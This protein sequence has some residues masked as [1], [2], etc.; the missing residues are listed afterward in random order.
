M[1]LDAGAYL[2]ATA[3]EAADALEFVKGAAMAAV[4]AY[5]LTV[6]AFAEAV[7]KLIRK[8]ASW[9]PARDDVG[10]PSDHVAKGNG[11]AVHRVVRRERRAR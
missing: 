3:L 1:E 6:E 8:A 4:R 9:S 11:K 5:V 10:S 2:R 7:I